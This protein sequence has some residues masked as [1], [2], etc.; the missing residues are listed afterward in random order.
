M[1]C[2][3]FPEGCEHP[4]ITLLP[5]YHWGVLLIPCLSTVCSEPRRV[6]QPRRTRPGDHLVDRSNCCVPSRTNLRAR[7]VRPRQRSGRLDAGTTYQE[8]PE[9]HCDP[10]T[11]HTRRAS[12]RTPPPHGADAACPIREHRRLARARIP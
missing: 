7:T 3:A 8:I 5:C 1:L 10:S 11:D 12:Q 2:L 6:R 9:R 4:I